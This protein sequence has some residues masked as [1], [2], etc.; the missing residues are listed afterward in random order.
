MSYCVNC[1]VELANSEK[2]CPLCGVE[3]LNPARTGMEEL[4]GETYPSQREPVKS[5]F[6]RQMWITIVSIVLAVPA[7]ICFVSNMLFH[8]SG[9]W[10]FY[11]IGALAVA[12]TLGVSPF[13][14]KR[15][16][17]LL[18]IVAVTGAS[19]GYLY[20]IEFL[21]PM[22]GWFLPL[23]LPIVLGMAVLSLAIIVLIRRKVLRQ[24]F[25]PAAVFLA[26]GLLAVLVELSISLY[27][28]HALRMVWSWFALIS[29]VAMAGVLIFIERQLII[30]EKLKRRLHI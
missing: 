6:D 7:A 17:P 11:V 9:F 16:F 24:L 1:G 22:Q 13:L 26:L 15:Y 28:E 8:S 10:S 30:K 2:R 29:C 20:L 14:F 18:W 21:S 5:I 25:T 12:W 19:L 27:T 23:A 4:Y 3:V